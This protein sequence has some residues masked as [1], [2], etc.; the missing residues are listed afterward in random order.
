LSLEDDI[1][2]G[3][4]EGIE[5][6]LFKLGNLKSDESLCIITDDESSK[7]AKLF[8]RISNKHKIKT[9]YHTIENLKIHGQ[10]PP[11]N[12]ANAMKNCNLILGLTT[13][14]MAHTKARLNATNL[15]IRFLSLPNYTIDLLKDPSLRANFFGIEEKVKKIAEK[16]TKAKKIRIKTNSGTLL[17]LD[18]TNRKGNF[19]PGYVKNNII[20]GSPPDIEANV[21]PIEEKSEG[22]ILVDGSIPIK[23]LGKLDKPILLKIKKGILKSIEGDPKVEKFL[24]N[25]FE[26]YDQNARVLAEFGV[27]FNNRSKLCG[28]MLIDEG[29]YGTFHCGF[30]SNNTIGGKNKINFHLDFVFYANEIIFD[31]EIIQI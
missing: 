10:E 14:S 29:S 23:G 16:F 30:G 15:G 9:E 20:L 31:D 12:I 18:I 26:Q 13:N 21:P 17:E 25:L 2:R 27:G 1:E 7:I 4:V 3:I 8:H 28:N 22:Q 6:V 19:A 11:N 5:T 24:K